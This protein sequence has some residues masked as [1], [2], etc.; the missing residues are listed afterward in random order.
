GTTTLIIGVSIPISILF[1]F[2]G[3]RLKGQ[4]INLMTLGGLTVAIGMMVD[5]SIVV[6]ENIYR[7]FKE[8]KSAAEAASI[9]THEVGGAVIASTSTSLAA[10]IPLLF[11]EDFTGIILKDIAL[12]IIYSLSGAMI[13]AVVVVP[14][15]ASKI[16]KP[17]KIKES[18]RL[19]LLSSRIE[20]ILNTLSDQYLKILS[21]AIKNWKFVLLLAFSILCLS[22]LV[23]NLLGFQFLAPADMGEIQISVELPGSYNIEKTRDKLIEIENLIN[24]EVPEMKEGLF[25]AGLEDLFSSNAVADTGFILLSLIEQSER[26]RDVFQII[27]K[28]QY[29]I[30]HQIPDVKVSVKNGGLSA[31]M[32]AA[33]GGEGYSIELFGS[34]MSDLIGAGELLVD[35]LNND[36]D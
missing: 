33:T 20:G 9:G 27:D 12:T 2:I 34:N 10:F 16:L 25:Y 6:L 21:R 23:F 17:Q 29:E 14:F 5:S 3:L 32:A 8:G 31:M 36:P 11:L 28:L 7:H 35:Y 30:H 1:A 22:Y 13:V 19:H 15:L 18:S 4:S 26:K 24:R